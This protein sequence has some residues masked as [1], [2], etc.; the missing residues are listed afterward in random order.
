MRSL[1]SVAEVV[2]EFDVSD[3]TVQSLIADDKPLA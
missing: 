2:A 1:Y 3:Q